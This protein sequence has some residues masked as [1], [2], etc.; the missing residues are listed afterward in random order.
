LRKGRGVRSGHYYDGRAS[1]SCHYF[2]VVLEAHG[3]F[4]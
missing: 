4:S 3:L 2:V 1:K